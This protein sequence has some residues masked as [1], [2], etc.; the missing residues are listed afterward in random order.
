MHVEARRLK[1]IPRRLE[2]KQTNWTEL[3][4]LGFTFRVVQLQVA[5]LYTTLFSMKLYQYFGPQISL[6][7][8]FQYL[9]GAIPFGRR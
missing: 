2:H 3:K 6:V 8:I 7:Q 4:F 5:Y 9:T 1:I